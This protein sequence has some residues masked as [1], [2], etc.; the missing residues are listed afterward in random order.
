MKLIA[1]I[2]ARMTSSRMP[3]K[4]LAPLAGRVLIERVI[5]SVRAGMPFN[6]PV[7]VATSV[8][9]TDDPIHKYC[10]RLCKVFR[11][12]ETD[13]LER[14]Y[15]C[16]LESQAEYI[17]RVT[18]D[19]PLIC[20]T[21]IKTTVDDFMEIS[22]SYDYH[23]QV[24]NEWRRTCADGLDHEIFSMDALTRARCKAVGAEYHEHPTKWMWEN[25]LCL[26][27]AATPYADTHFSVNCIDDL[28]H[29]EQLIAECGENALGR[30][31]AEAS[32]RIR[33]QESKPS[34]AEPAVAEVP[35]GVSLEEV[36][37]LAEIVAPK[38]RKRKERVVTDGV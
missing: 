19:C 23:G 1:V 7:I 8:N 15:Q 31:Y 3:A 36:A 22:G 10:E 17:L 2:Q 5:S 32:K 9:Q 37:R 30:I 34:P 27:P 38:P 20:P 21:M 26:P 25:A 4:V 24:N 29:C 18:A 35:L 14:Y 16:A 6:T 33:G 13:V 11:G 12:S 28:K